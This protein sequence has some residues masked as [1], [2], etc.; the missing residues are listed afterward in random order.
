MSSSITA[1]EEK[2][3][4]ALFPRPFSLSKVVKL[5]SLSYPIVPGE[6][7]TP[8]LLN[9]HRTSHPPPHRGG[10]KI[11]FPRRSLGHLYEPSALPLP[12]IGPAPFPERLQR[13]GLHTAR[14][15]V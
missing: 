2:R 4:S 12:S 13:Y 3:L 10:R 15:Y 9:G 11:I 8:G 7:G 5:S 14:L 6:G 1:L